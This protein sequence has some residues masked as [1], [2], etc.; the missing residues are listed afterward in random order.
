MLNKIELLIK[1][2]FSIILPRFSAKHAKLLFALIK[3]ESLTASELI[4]ITKIPRSKIY[5]LLNDL[6]EFKLI[7]CKTGTP[8]VYHLDKPI[9]LIK[10]KFY[11]YQKKLESMKTQLLLNLKDE[12]KT[13]EKAYIIKPE[14]CKII[15]MNTRYEVK[16]LSIL[17]EIK[18]IIETQLDKN[19][20]NYF[21]YKF[22][23]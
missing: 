9:T 20:F 4:Q 19:Y 10:R 16:D 8:K 13:F 2:V 3:A 14:K 18:K 22:K 6:I 1:D 17:K 5:S 21:N 12:S 23:H 11:E 15:D 7:E